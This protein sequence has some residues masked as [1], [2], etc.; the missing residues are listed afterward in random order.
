[1]VFGCLFDFRWNLW[2][3]WRFGVL[4][5]FVP[6]GFAVRLIMVEFC[7]LYEWVGLII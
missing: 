5:V 1:M 4:V 6:F 3:F 7:V 2:N